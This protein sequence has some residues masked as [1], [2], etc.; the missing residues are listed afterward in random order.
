MTPQQQFEIQFL[1][2]MNTLAFIELLR[3]EPLTDAE[4]AK[5]L[6][7]LRGGSETSITSSEGTLTSS[8]DNTS[9][10]GKDLLQG[11]TF[12]LILI[13]LLLSLKMFRSFFVIQHLNNF[14]AT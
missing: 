8:D 10:E 6:E 2:E 5:V 11:S 3:G 14:K 4:K 7:D 9:D 1:D 12:F 13:L